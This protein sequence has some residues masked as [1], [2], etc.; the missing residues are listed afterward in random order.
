[1][2]IF[3]RPQEQCV[4]HLLR[5]NG[6]PTDDVYSLDLDLF[7]GCGDEIDPA[8][9]VGLEI[10][11]NNGLL[12]SLAVRENSRNIGCGKILVAGIEKLAIEK[13]LKSLYLL[14]SNAEEYFVRLNYTQIERSEVPQPIKK[15]QEFSCL[16]PESA[17]VMMKR[18]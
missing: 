13:K 2:H 9:V 14:T 11:G 12:R 15:T 3:R 5:Q 8:G 7:L 1:M 6:L 10:H 16:C 18:L 4:V 17:I